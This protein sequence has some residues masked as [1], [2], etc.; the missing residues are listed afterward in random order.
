[1]IQRRKP[2]KRST[3][4]LRRTRI[5][6]ISDRRRRE[7]AEY[8]K[9]RIPFLKAHPV[10]EVWCKE[11]GW[12][13]AWP[14]VYEKGGNTLAGGYLV[15]VERAPLATE[16][17][18]VAKRRGAALNDESKWLAVCRANHRRIEENLSWA[19]AN[20]FADNF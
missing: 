12:R 5:K 9:R 8:S 15:T 13:W 6:P 19:R 20:G 14:D 1:M 18:H 16:V 2:L 7:K 3:V 4:P 17:H 10:C 11:N